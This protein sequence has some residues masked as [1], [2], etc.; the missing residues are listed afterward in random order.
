MCETGIRVS[1]SA[2]K[3]EGSRELEAIEA[4]LLMFMEEKKMI[5]SPID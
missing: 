4:A 2:D 5:P 1:F 3:H